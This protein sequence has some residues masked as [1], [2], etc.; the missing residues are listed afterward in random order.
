MDPEAHL[1][2]N[3]DDE[4]VAVYLAMGQESSESVSPPSSSSSNRP[5]TPIDS[6]EDDPDSGVKSEG[7][8]LIDFMSL[9]SVTSDDVDSSGSSSISEVEITYTIASTVQQRSIAWL[10]AWATLLYT[11]VCY[12]MVSTDG[13]I[14]WILFPVPI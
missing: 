14:H 2:T 12:L 6:F 13:S 4:L 5:D 9:S 7:D 1:C 10:Q 3:E 8:D 11:A